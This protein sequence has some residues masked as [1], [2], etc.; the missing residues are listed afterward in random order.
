MSTVS[1]IN[2]IV[3]IDGVNINEKMAKMEKELSRAAP[4]MEAIAKVLS[5][6]PFGGS[7]QHTNI[8]MALGTAVR[9][10]LLRG[11]AD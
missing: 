2:G 4:I 7:P 3:T 5:G 10:V 11:S 8:E 6:W 1:V 9:Q